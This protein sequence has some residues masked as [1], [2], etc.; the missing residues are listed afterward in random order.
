VIVH[1]DPVTRHRAPQPP[2]RR[3]GGKGGGQNSGSNGNGG[4]SS[5]NHTGTHAVTDDVKNALAQIAASTLHT[6]QD[7]ASTATEQQGASLAGTPSAGTAS[8]DT[9][10]RDAQVR[11]A[12]APDSQRVESR[13]GEPRE[14]ERAAG[15]QAHPRHLAGEVAFAG[16]ADR[17]DAPRGRRGSRGRGARRIQD[18]ADKT[19][20]PAGAFDD[21]SDDAA[22][23]QSSHSSSAA[24]IDETRAS[25]DRDA[26]ELPAAQTA[27][28]GSSRPAAAVSIL[29]IPVAAHV[30][31][32]PVVDPAQAQEILGSVLDAL[33][34]PKKPGQG[35][36]R[37]RVTT[38]GLTGGTVATQA[39]DSQA[40]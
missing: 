38:A 22:D 19:V 3:R 21:R 16:R 1:H 27:S 5:T 23:A 35:R 7:P 12:Q 30:D 8:S 15:D 26:G 39:D 17:Q 34:E 6:H 24:A 31:Q 29:D 14:D 2:E 18:D 37:R 10:A 9:Q 32:K 4:A 11:E 20:Q 33:P 13:S 40:S 28:E 36:S 25:R